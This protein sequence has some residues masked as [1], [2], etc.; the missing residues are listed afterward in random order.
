[1]R[2]AAASPRFKSM[3]T[4]DVVYL[5]GTRHALS[6]ALAK[7]DRGKHVRK[8]EGY[9]RLISAAGLRRAKTK[10]FWNHPSRR[11]ARYFTTTLERDDASR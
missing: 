10:L 3:F 11:L 9:E 8:P 5:P 6:N 7:F 2:A 1:M 4:L